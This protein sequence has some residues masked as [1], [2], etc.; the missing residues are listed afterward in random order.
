MSAQLA[1]VAA[2]SSDVN[3]EFRA[4]S[5]SH[6]RSCSERST[7]QRARSLVDF[8]ADNSPTG[9]GLLWEK[10]YCWLTE[11]NER[12]YS[13]FR[14]HTKST[15]FSSGTLDQWI[16]R[17]FARQT[18]ASIRQALLKKSFCCTSNFLV[19]LEFARVNWTYAG[20]RQ[21]CSCSVRVPNWWPGA[22]GGGN[23]QPCSVF[24]FHN[25][26]VS[27]GL[28]ATKIISRTA[29]CPSELRN[30]RGPRW[31]GLPRLPSPGTPRAFVVRG[32]TWVAGLKSPAVG[33]RAWTSRYMPLQAVDAEAAAPGVALARPAAGARRL[34][35]SP[36]HG[37]ELAA[38]TS[39]WSR[40]CWALCYLCA[41]I[42]KKIYITF[43][44]CCENIFFLP[45]L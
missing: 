45:K 10:K 18:D 7:G 38:R 39:F 27:I 6:D 22:C 37:N 20:V 31:R 9:A 30:S 33:N 40:G 2:A 19:P 14:R 24:F 28:S 26:S 5:Q 25:K 17:F 3:S 15:R 11:I 35:R 42:E 32:V 13:F 16:R 36:W 12:T 4:S 41:R 8:W 1:V 44:N 21:H 23:E 34:H 43:L 29:L